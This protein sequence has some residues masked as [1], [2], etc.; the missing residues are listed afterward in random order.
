MTSDDSTPP[1]RERWE[2]SRLRER[3]DQPIE[4]ASE[5]TRKTLGWYP[6]RVWRHFLQGNGFLLAASISYQSLF[7]IFATLYTAF[8]VAGLWLGGSDAAVDGLIA[9]V[10]SYVPDLISTDGA[11]HPEDVEE[12]AR[13]SGSLLAV[14]GAVAL[15]VAIWTAI[16]FVTFTRR[17]VR[18]IF[19]LPF[20]TRNFVLLKVRDFIA[21]LL[22]GIALV[23]GATFGL[24]AGGMATLVFDWFE[25][26]YESRAIDVL[27]RVASVV[28]GFVV[29]GA[30]LTALIR[31]LTGT[32]LPWRSI[33]PG[34]M[35][36]GAALS[37]LQLGAGFLAV[38]SP[39][40]PL[41]ATFSVI[42]GFLLWLR[43]AGIVILVA[44]SAVAVSADDDGIPLVHLTDEERA[45]AERRAARVVARA[46]VRD[47][48]SALDEASW[49]RR[50]HAALRLRDAQRELEEL[51]ED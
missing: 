12:I 3:L 16:G 21:A 29:N 32:S 17:A 27:S 51:E 49:W 37:L 24:I 6:I 25:V 19:E 48:A 45:A 35:F 5:V 41:L 42:I 2:A 4:R 20:D 14:T 10:N 28:V 34:A 9:I 18:D 13:T 39:T 47:A 36:G 11:V 50:P 43:L 22:F 38:Y 7:A 23:L 15:G 1:L 44:A 26:P 33:A 8:A 31:F 40:N 46:R 30:A